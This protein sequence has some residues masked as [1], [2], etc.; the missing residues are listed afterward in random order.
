MSKLTTKKYQ[1]WNYVK[2]NITW[3]SLVWILSMSKAASYV[4]EF[5]RNDFLTNVLTFLIRDPWF[6]CHVIV[7]YKYM[8]ANPT[9]IYLFKVGMTMLE[10]Y[11]LELYFE[12]VNANGSLDMTFLCE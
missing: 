2:H 10:H 4:Q 11:S 1:K 9:S 8:L 3:K 12:Q 6:L 7:D 5:H